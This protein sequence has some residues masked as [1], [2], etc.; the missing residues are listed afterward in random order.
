[1][2]KTLAKPDDV[3]KIE[4]IKRTVTP[5]NVTS[6]EFA[7]FIYQARRTGLDPLTRQIYIVKYEG[8]N[9]KAS[10]QATIDGLR[11]VAQRSGQYAGQD[12]PVFTRE[13]GEQMKCTVTVYRFGPDKQRYPA[14]VGVA[15]WDEYYPGD[16]RGF[17]WNKMPHTMLAK[18][19]EAL[20][21]R[22][23][24][25]Q[26]LSGL[27]TPEEMGQAEVKQTEPVIDAND[28]ETRVEY[29]QTDKPKSD[30]GK[31]IMEAMKK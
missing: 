8:Q 10:I 3:K 13:E 6:D 20:A 31:K 17:M 1:M 25:P 23:A 14:A 19:A 24:F 29:E 15:Y 30:A 27:Y 22:K 9:A 5:T 12:E 18:C 16:K 28:L 4:L 2:T 7:M 11:L 26:E 21:L